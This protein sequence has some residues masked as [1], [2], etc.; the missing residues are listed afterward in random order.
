MSLQLFIELRQMPQKQVNKAFSLYLNHVP[1][2]Y[3]Y[4]LTQVQGLWPCPNKFTQ[5]LNRDRMYLLH[6]EENQ[7][8]E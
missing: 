4:S 8:Q 1:F 3:L 6:Q 2:G 7:N 5:V